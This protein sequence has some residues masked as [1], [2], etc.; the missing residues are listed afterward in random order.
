MKVE[1]EISPTQSLT[2]WRVDFEE[3][4]RHKVRRRKPYVCDYDGEEFDTY[5]EWYKH[6]AD[7]S[8]VIIK[9]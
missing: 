7:A 9:E 6:R 2:L 4:A 3:K 1:S 5:K 8:T